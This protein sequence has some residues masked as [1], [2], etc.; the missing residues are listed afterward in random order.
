M[1]GF[2]VGVVSLAIGIDLLSDMADDD[3]PCDHVYNNIDIPTC[4]QVSKSRGKSA[5]SR[6]Y[7]SASAR[8]AA[9][10]AG[11]PIPPLDT[12]NN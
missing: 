8:Y 7:A 9:C 11:K 1:I 10:I 5:G 6:C 3:D 12:W 2:C 4:R